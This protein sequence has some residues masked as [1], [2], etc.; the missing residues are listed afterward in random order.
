MPDPNTEDDDDSGSLKSW[1]NYK[2]WNARGWQV[3]LAVA[4]IAFI[5][6]SICEYFYA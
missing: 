2:V 6:G 5:A 4:A 3:L 1:L